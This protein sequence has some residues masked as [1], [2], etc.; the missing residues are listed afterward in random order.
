MSLQ[1]LTTGQ[2]SDKKTLAAAMSAVLRFNDLKFE[3]MLP[4]IVILFDRTRNVAT[5][6]PLITW[7]DINDNARP[8]SRYTEIPVL[9]LGGGGFHVSFPLKP[10]DLGWIHASDRDLSQ[11]RA[12]LQQS[13]PNT[14]R[15]H[16]F[17]DGMFVPDVYRQYTINGE[18]TTAMVIQS[19]DGA[20]RISV[21]P[22]N[23]KITAPTL[24]TIDAPN[25]HFTGNVTVDKTLTATVDA[26]VAGIS[27]KAH[28]HQV[29]AVGA[30]TGGAMIA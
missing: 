18:D 23:V 29:V 2:S 25:A 20:T 22:D 6:Q 30:R 28:G 10:G 27:V 11:F 4:A 14:G 8:R 26:V 16:K 1:P 12:S 24:V 21:R 7:V 13:K 15:C 5:V 19:T 17:E 3:V 9:S